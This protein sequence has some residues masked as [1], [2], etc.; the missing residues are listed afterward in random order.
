MWESRVHAPVMKQ[1]LIER[2]DTPTHVVSHAIPSVVAAEIEVAVFSLSDAIAFA[3]ENSPRLRIAMEAV[4][5][6]EGQEMVAFAPFLPEVDMFLR[7]GATTFNLS[8]GAPGP[9]GGIV[10][11]NL[12]SGHQFAQ[13][14]MDAQYLVWDFGRRSGRYGQAV[15][16]QRIASAQLVRAR[17]TTAFDVTS[18]YFGVLLAQ[19]NQRVRAE[20][21]RRAQAILDDTRHRRQGGVADRDDVLRA[22]VQFSETREALVEA[23]QAEYEAIARLNYVMGRNASLPIRLV[24]WRAESH[25][26]PSL[27]ECLQ[28]AAAQRPEVEVARDGVA[29]A[30]HGLDAI[31]G[32]FLPKVYIRGS[33][34]QVGGD[35]ILTGFHQGAALHL[36]QSLYTGRRRQGEQRSAEA[37]VRAAMASAQSIFDTIT[38]EVN[39]AYRSLMA[40]RARIP[41]AKTSITQ[42][43][44]NLRLVRVKYQNGDA[45]PTDVVDGET[46]ATRS[47]QRYYSALYESL[48]ALARLEYA[49]G[50]PYGSLFQGTVGPGPVQLHAPRPEKDD[51]SQGGNRQ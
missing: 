16:R 39:L 18:A 25:A 23:E 47:E 34:G 28:T 9:T 6:A 49:M 13:A 24:D 2:V 46:A 30:Q 10:P 3:M 36:D 7:Y 22:E 4:P 51:A 33:V 35:G 29:V 48:N 5:R 8:P 26:D 40:A 11:A 21:V 1:P 20:A 43:Q 15:S 37:D 14:E 38:L 19:A 41:L 27:V 42:A 12:T 17:Q 50:A 45:T 32:E 44:E 31:R